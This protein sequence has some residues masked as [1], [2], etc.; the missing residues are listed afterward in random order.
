[1]SSDKDLRE[2]S[3]GITVVVFGKAVSNGSQRSLVIF[4]FLHETHITYSG[5]YKGD[6]ISLIWLKTWN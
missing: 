3:V 6:H 4:F 5:D 2:L 1:M